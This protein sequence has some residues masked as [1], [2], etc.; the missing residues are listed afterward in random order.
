MI[1]AAFGFYTAEE[2]VNHQPKVVFVDGENRLSHVG[3]EVAG[4]EIRVVMAAVKSQG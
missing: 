3:P 2:S 4:P 1:V